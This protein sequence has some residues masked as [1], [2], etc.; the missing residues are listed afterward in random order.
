[1]GL[2]LGCGVW[3]QS[4]K[5]QARLKLQKKTSAANIQSELSEAVVSR[6]DDVAVNAVCGRVQRVT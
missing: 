6:Y 3:A 5:A 1:M 4:L 2:G